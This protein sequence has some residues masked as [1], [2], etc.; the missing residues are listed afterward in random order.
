M[1]MSS[2]KE[3]ITDVGKLIEKSELA[4]LL[5]K[6]WKKIE[7]VAHQKAN[8][9]EAT[10]SAEGNATIHLFPALMENAK[11]GELVLREFGRLILFRSD[12]NGQAIWE[13]KL[14]VPTE[15]AIALAV[16][17]LGDATLRQK[18]NEFKDVLDY[19]PERGHSVERLVYINI[20]NALLANNL[21]Y[22]DSVNADLREWGPC[23]EYCA[24]KKYHSLI[25]L[26]SAYAPANIHQDFGSAL[27]AL[28]VDN[29]TQVRDKSV[30]FALRGIVQRIAKLAC[31]D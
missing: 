4:E 30:A 8:G 23:A 20:V 24:R 7:W 14:D 10:L 2:Y 6:L 16:S 27:A 22:G 29:L 25:P 28:I 21:S 26:T 31:A 15:A 9:D 13:K 17:K 19:Y 18:C 5:T 1:D 11:A 3:I 12:K